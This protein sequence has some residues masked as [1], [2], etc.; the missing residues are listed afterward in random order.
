VGV[1]ANLES[2]GYV[3][4]RLGFTA[5]D[6][7]FVQSLSEGIRRLG[8][9]R[10]SKAPQLS[11]AAK[12]EYERL[13]TLITDY[14]D[15]RDPYITWNVTRL[16]TENLDRELSGEISRHMIPVNANVPRTFVRAA[17]YD[18]SW[19]GVIHLDD[20]NEMAVVNGYIEE[21]KK[22]RKR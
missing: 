16:N 22:K 1:Y 2:G 3:W 7:S 10:G 15:T 6:E 9:M 12:D 5:E 21:S 13:E 17:L 14:G 19:K 4:A 11:A 8:G 20:E 18:Q